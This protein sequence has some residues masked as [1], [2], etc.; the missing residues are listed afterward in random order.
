MH[1]TPDTFTGDNPVARTERNGGQPIF[2]DI[3]KTWCGRT[4]THVTV[5]P[6]VDLTDLIAVPGSEVPDRLKAQIKHRDLTCVFPHCTKPAARSDKDHIEPFDEG[7]TTD[8]GGGLSLRHHR[9]KTHGQWHYQRID[10][11]TYLWTNHLGQQYLRDHQG[12][13][14]ILRPPRDAAASPAPANSSHQ[15][16]NHHRASDLVATCLATDRRFPRRQFSQP[17]RV[18]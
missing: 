8:S 14:A 12:T 3:V 4:D 15:H 13:T 10:P 1:L 18:A 17:K 2:A 9:I 16:P 7:G 5:T 6:V 11:R